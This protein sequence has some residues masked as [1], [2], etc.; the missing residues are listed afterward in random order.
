MTTL[1]LEAPTL[2]LKMDEHGVIRVAGT[3][4]PLDNIVY[5]YQRGMS[6]EE[7]A[8]NY[9]TLSLADVY[10]AITFY[11]CNQVE[12]EAYLQEQEQE[13]EAIWEKIEALPT[14]QQFRTMLRQRIQQKSNRVV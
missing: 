14:N 6:A 12:V 2:P 13:I 1:L 7:I 3:R 9:S 10:A 5:N 4:I 8:D 11:L